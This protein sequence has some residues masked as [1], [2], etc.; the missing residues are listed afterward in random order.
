MMTACVS[1]Q[2]TFRQGSTSWKLVFHDS[3]P[4]PNLLL[5]GILWG[6]FLPQ[7][8]FSVQNKKVIQM[9]F[10]LPASHYLKGGGRPVWIKNSSIQHCCLLQ[11]FICFQRHSLIFFHYH[12]ECGT[13]SRGLQRPDQIQ[14]VVVHSISA[15]RHKIAVRKRAEIYRSAASAHIIYTKKRS[16][17]K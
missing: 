15:C 14:T 13:V 7:T 6:V 16:E 17:V 8:D 11:N 1:L 4:L 5:L 2:Q 9:C 12:M 3:L 10:L